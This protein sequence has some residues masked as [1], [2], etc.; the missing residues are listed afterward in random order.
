MGAGEPSQGRGIAVFYA[1]ERRIA[2]LGDGRSSD[3]VATGRELTVFD[4]AK[5]IGGT[6]GLGTNGA[7][8]GRSVSGNGGCGEETG[9]ARRL[10][11]PALCCA[12][13]SG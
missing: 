5:Q 8:S 7:N 11:A 12:V 4:G 6:L 9:I 13:V 1:R 10:T 3:A 2:G